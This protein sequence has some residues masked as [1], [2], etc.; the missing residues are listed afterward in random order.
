MIVATARERTNHLPGYMGRS[1]SAVGES[2]RPGPY[3]GRMYLENLVFDALEPQRLGAV[4]GSGRRRGDAL[5]DEPDILETRLE[6]SRAGRSSTCA[7]SAVPE[8]GRPR[9]STLVLSSAGC[10]P[11]RGGRA[12]CSGWAPG[13]GIAGPPVPWAC[14]PTRRA[15]R[16]TST[17]TTRRTPTPVRWRPSARLGRPGPRRG[18][19]GM[20]DRVDP[21]TLPAGTPTARGSSAI[22]PGAD[23]CSSCGPRRTP[24]GASQEPA[25]PR[26]PARAGRGPRRRR[27]RHRRARRRCA[28]HGWGELPWRSY[29]DPSGNELCVLPAPS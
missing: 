24:K 20:A 27:G 29:T 16:S 23:L 19:L 26:R 15:T 18:V 14:S 3:G 8:P 6:P 13:A 5:T 10:R 22:P 12:R 4:L 17:G 28:P 21:R 7:S 1:S 25:A 2:V 9:G 11:G